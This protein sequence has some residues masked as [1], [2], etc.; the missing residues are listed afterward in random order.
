MSL[1]AMKIKLL[2]LRREGEGIEAPNVELTI[3]IQGSNGRL[4]FSGTLTVQVP[5]T[6]LPDHNRRGPSEAA[7]QAVGSIAEAFVTLQNAHKAP[8]LE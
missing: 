4:P 3:R 1:P 5:E 6:G 8:D 7:L 2:S